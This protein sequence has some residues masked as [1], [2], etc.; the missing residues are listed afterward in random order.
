VYEQGTAGAT[1]APQNGIA[2]LNGRNEI[3]YGAVINH[4]EPFNGATGNI[5]LASA[6]TDLLNQIVQNSPHL[7]VIA[8]SSNLTT[9][10][11]KNPNTG[12]TERVTVPA[13]SDAIASRR[14]CMDSGVRFRPRRGL[15]ASSA[16]RYR[17]TA[18]PCSRPSA[19]AAL[20][21]SDIGV[22][23]RFDLAGI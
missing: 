10:R 18:L 21:V 15:W 3:V 23:A 1:I 5:T 8:R 13:S 14:F 7:R 20:W 16:S 2:D 12:I 11:G 6:T 9:L 19:N 4:Y 22:L 17:R